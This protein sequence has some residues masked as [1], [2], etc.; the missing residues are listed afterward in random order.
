MAKQTKGTA[1]KYKKYIDIVIN[2]NERSLD[3]IAYAVGLPYDIVAKDLQDMI[4]IGY[5][6]GAFINHGNREISFE[7]RQPAVVVQQAAPGQVPV[8]TQ[9][10]RCPGCG[11]NNVVVV[12]RVTECEY[13]GTPINA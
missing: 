13:C 3:N 9:A 11:A 4:N 1:E 10:V 12:G 2:R 6:R 5:L 7:Q 8:Q